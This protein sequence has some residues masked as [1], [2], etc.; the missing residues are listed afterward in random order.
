MPLGPPEAP[1]TAFNTRFVDSTGT[2]FGFGGML[3]AVMVRWGAK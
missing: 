2:K 1:A 3:T